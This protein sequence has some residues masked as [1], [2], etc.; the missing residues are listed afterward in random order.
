MVSLFTHALHEII[1]YCMFY[2]I[3]REFFSILH[4]CCCYINLVWETPVFIRCIH[5]WLIE[6]NVKK[7]TQNQ[8][9]LSHCMLTTQ[10]NGLGHFAR[11]VFTVHIFRRWKKTAEFVSVSSTISCFKCTLFFFQFSWI[12]LNQYP[13][14]NRSSCIFLTSMKQ[15]CS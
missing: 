14:I 1:I 15:N 11:Q 13:L 6:E 2:S 3:G 10:A 9:I 4:F 8:Y 12:K 5:S 7:H